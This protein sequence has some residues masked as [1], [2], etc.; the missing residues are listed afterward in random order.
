MERGRVAFGSRDLLR[1]VD[2]VTGL[3]GGEADFFVLVLTF[4]RRVEA[5][6]VARCP[7]DLLRDLDGVTESSRGKA[8]FSLL[9]NLVAR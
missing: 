6:R 1:D 3:S 7:C 8:E 5:D 2:G 9:A 4:D